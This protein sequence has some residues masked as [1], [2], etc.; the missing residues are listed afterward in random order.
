MGPDEFNYQMLNHLQENS[1]E[2]LL[3]I[4]N[5]IWTTGKFNWRALA[6]CLCTI[7]E[8]NINKRLKR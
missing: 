7:L 4:L 8:N 3:N 5:Y 1:L 6:S 2:P